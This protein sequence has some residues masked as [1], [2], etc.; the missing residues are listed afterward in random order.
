MLYILLNNVLNDVK[1]DKY[2]WEWVLNGTE[3][4]N[5]V[6]VPKIFLVLSGWNVAMVTEGQKIIY[7]KGKR[8]SLYSV[9]GC[10]SEGK[11]M[12]PVLFYSYGS[13]H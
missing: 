2:P 7:F 12:Q 6:S 5:V 4:I 1:I 13:R 9:D 8:C 3:V 11:D 10:S